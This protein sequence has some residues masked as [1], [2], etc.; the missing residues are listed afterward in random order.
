[1]LHTVNRKLTVTYIIDK[2]ITIGLFLLSAIFVFI[3]NPTDVVIIVIIF[4][5]YWFGKAYKD[6]LLFLLDCL[7]RSKSTMFVYYSKVMVGDQ[8]F[9]TLSYTIMSCDSTLTSTRKLT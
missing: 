4:G 5:A 2:L 7:T 1:M 6:A 9:S 8:F 3:F